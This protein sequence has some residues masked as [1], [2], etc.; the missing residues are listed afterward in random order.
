MT[1]APCF[2][3]TSPAVYDYQGVNVCPPHLTLSCQLEVDM[4]KQDRK[5]FNGNYEKVMEMQKLRRH[6]NRE[7]RHVFKKKYKKGIN[8][9]KTIKAALDK[10][11]KH[12]SFE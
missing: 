7:T 2:F 12:A 4:R 10:S 11:F 5:D 9:V 8:T 1:S 6:A 3:C